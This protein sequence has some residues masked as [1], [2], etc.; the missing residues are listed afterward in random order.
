MVVAKSWFQQS[1][2]ASSKELVQLLFNHFQKNVEFTTVVPEL[3]TPFLERG[4]MR[5]HE[6]SC[7]CMIGKSKAMICIEG[8]QISPS[9]N[10]RWTKVSS[11]ESY[12]LSTPYS[13]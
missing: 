1:V 6:V 12:A 9:E 7:T 11:S 13:S 3:V 5:N 10:K 2:V 4:E 8:K